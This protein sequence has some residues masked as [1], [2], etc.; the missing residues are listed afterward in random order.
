MLGRPLDQEVRRGLLGPAD[1]GPD[2]GIARRQRAVRQGRPVLAHLGV[3]GVAARRIDHQVV[4]RPDPLHIGPKFG[5]PAEVNGEVHAQAGRLGHRVDQPPEGRTA[6][7]REVAALGKESGGHMAGVQPLEL[8]RQ[9]RRVQTGGIDHRGGSQLRAV[10]RY[11][12]HSA[13]E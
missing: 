5:L 9:R 11:K 10:I 1:L 2:A 12:N 3:E 7:Q 4:G 13:S 6:R 8:P